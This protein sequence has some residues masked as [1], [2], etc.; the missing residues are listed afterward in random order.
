VPSMVLVL[1]RTAV[2][3][4]LELCKGVLRV[5]VV[6]L[7]DLCRRD[8]AR[9]ALQKAH[10]KVILKLPHTTAEPGLGMFSDRA[11]AEK[12]PFSTT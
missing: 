5:A 10:A 6:F 2:S 3:A 8:D 9:C 11:A 4:T 1:R 7:A 12:P